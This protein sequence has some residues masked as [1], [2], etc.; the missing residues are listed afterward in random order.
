MTQLER[1]I[2]RVVQFVEDSQNKII[3]ITVVVDG[4]GVP[5]GWNIS[6]ADAEYLQ[7]DSK[8]VVK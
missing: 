6:Q 5:V 3:T 8:N 1:L 7:L 2:A 4:H